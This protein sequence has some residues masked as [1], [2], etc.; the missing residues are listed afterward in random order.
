MKIIKYYLTKNDCYKKGRKRT[1]TL[2]IIRHDTAAGNKYLK[3]YIDDAANLGENKYKNG[4]NMPGKAKCVHFMIGLDKNGEIAIYQTLPLDYVCWGCGSGKK[5]SYNKSHIQYEILDDGYKDKEYF[6]KAMKAADWL[7]AYLCQ[8][9]NLSVNSITCHYDAYK[10]GYATNHNDIIKWLKNFGKDMNWV[11]TCVKK[12]M[13]KAKKEVDNKEEPKT[14]KA[15]PGAFKVKIITNTLNVR[16]AAGTENKIVCTVK[17][18]MSIR[19]LR[20]KKAEA[21]EN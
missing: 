13:N 16:A 8:K 19:L 11:R 3:R 4:W 1:K 7:D 5:G 14:D 12:E 9:Y 17:K 20:L 2:G 15:I 21:G 18:V 10:K 6:E